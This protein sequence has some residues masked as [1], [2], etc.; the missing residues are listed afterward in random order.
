MN[1]KNSIMAKYM[2]WRREHMNII[3]PYFLKEKQ[4][5][6][7]IIELS[8]G[9]GFSNT[10]LWGVTIIEYSD[11][12]FNCGNE[13]SESFVDKTKAEI[14]YDGFTSIDQLRK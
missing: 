13:L 3:T 10:K 2:K 7:F 4:I 8:E 14:Y 5:G 11:G 6:N 9:S 12:K 1:E